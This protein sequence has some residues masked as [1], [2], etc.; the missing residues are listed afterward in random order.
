MTAETEKQLVSDVADIK[1]ILIRRE[2][3]HE[4]CM[5]LSAT[6]YGNGKVGLCTKVYVL[7][8]VLGGLGAV[9]VTVAG[10]LAV[11]AFAGN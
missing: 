3:C 10:A 11:K 2:S 4:A 9:A 1:A 8:M 5:N 7:M 6:V